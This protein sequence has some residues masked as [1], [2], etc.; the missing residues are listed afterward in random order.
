MLLRIHLLG[1][2]ALLSTLVSPAAAQHREPHANYIL[3]CAGCHG[4]DG[5]GVP[6]AGV[7]AFPGY[8]GVFAGDED[9]RTYLLNV[10][11]VVGASL[12]DTEIAALMNY[13]VVRWAGPSLP[14]DFALFT[15]AEV[16]ARRAIFIP[17][18]VGFRRAIVDRLARLG[19]AA[20]D[21][22]WP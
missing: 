17:G 9:G 2:V 1:L 5:T 13:V 10:P 19:L 21:Y 4:L 16:T 18:I 15:E 20:A 8:I 6:D 3:R 22:P 12:S 7:P 14:P 11:G